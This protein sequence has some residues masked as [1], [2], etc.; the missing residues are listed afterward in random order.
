MTNITS[1]E[2]LRSVFNPRVSEKLQLPAEYNEGLFVAVE[3]DPITISLEISG[4]QVTKIIIHSKL[5]ETPLYDETF[6]GFEGGMNWSSMKFFNGYQKAIKEHIDVLAQDHGI[7][8][9]HE[10]KN[11]N[12]LTVTI[13]KE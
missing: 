3:N 7:S 5:D 11:V 10:A 12:D 9:N 2:N 1:Y 8:V 6:M 4:D 13:T